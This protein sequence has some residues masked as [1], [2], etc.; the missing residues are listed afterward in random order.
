MTTSHVYELT[1]SDAAHITGPAHTTFSLDDAGIE[2]YGFTAIEFDAPP[3]RKLRD[4]VI[5][6]RTTPEGTTRTYLSNDLVKTLTGEPGYLFTERFELT[7]G[8][9]SFYLLSDAILSA[10]LA[11]IDYPSRSQRETI[12]RDRNYA[13]LTF[14]TLV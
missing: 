3:S 8:A 10:A 13:I 9:R 2:G 6:V 7:I 12:T 11:R 4:H 1:L 14:A 5:I